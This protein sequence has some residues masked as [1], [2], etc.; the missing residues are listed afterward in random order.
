MFYFGTFCPIHRGHIDLMRKCEDFIR[1]R[2]S[3]ELVGGFISPCHASYMYDKLKELSIQN[4]MRN[5]LIQ[6]AIQDDEMW[7]LDPFMSMTE[8][9]IISNHKILLLFHE[10]LR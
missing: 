7:T 8:G 9:G 6:L 1:A 3:H 10:R 2:S 5:H 4:S